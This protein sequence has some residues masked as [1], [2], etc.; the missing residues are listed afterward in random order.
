ML[1]KHLKFILLGS[2]TIALT[3]GNSHADSSTYLRADVYHAKGD[4]SQN[5]F[6]GS[7]ANHSFTLN[8]YDASRTA[9]Q[10][11]LGY[12]WSQF[13]YTEVG[14]LD[15]GDTE[16]DLTLNGNEDSAA[17]GKNFSKHFPRTGSGITLTQGLSLALNS[18][19]RASGE[20]GLFSWKDKAKL[21]AATIQFKD[22]NGL[23]LILGVRLDY[24]LSNALGLGLSARRVTLDNQHVDLVG[25]SAMWKF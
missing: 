3:A 1:I 8:R 6:A 25:A 23:D 10:L 21:N 17:F 5:D 22:E 14:Y 19:W 20:I 13:T 4:Q 24:Q 15:L 11:A 18:Q 9:A 2:I 16:V 12:Q 7:L